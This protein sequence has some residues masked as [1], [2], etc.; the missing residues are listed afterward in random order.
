MSD[1]SNSLRYK[2][3]RCPPHTPPIPDEVKEEEQE[4][5]NLEEANTAGGRS[6]PTGAA[7]SRAATPNLPPNEPPTEP[8]TTE[9]ATE[10]PVIAIS[11]GSDRPHTPLS[12]PS[13][14]LVASGS[15]IFKPRA[16]PKDKG[17]KAPL[18]VQAKRRRE[19]VNRKVRRDAA[20][21]ATRGN[22]PRTTNTG[23]RNAGNSFDQ[24]GHNP[25]TP[26]L[27]TPGEVYGEV[28]PR[29][30]LTVTRP[31]AGTGA[32]QGVVDSLLFT[33]GNYTIGHLRSHP[34][35]VAF[36][37]GNDGSAEIVRRALELDGWTVVKT[38]I[39]SGST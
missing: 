13:P 37:V 22:T 33:P 5:D 25:P 31:G 16:G 10:P 3:I 36:E 26:R 17:N 29:F 35:G 9:M 28:D 18:S 12:R 24:P 4:E 19:R 34:D 20:F 23:E 32:R 7:A 11:L 14:L 1:S 8:P 27:R 6:T 30:T 2:E 39:P 15:G 21:F 38:P